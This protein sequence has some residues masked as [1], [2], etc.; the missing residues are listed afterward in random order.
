M[1]ESVPPAEEGAR[2]PDEGYARAA[3]ILLALAAVVG[4]TLGA[5]A[6]LL[7]S[8]ATDAWQSA[9]RQEIKRAAASVEDVRFVYSDEGPQVFSIDVARLRA[10]ELRKAAAAATGQ[11]RE[12]LTLEAETYSRYVAQVAK[13]PLPVGARYRTPEGGFDAPKRLADNRRRYP[14]LVAIDPQEPQRAGD[15][16]SRRAMFEIAATIPAALAFLLGALAEVFARPRRWLLL[17]GAA[18]VAAAAVAG[19]VL[20]VVT[21]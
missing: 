3:A 21:V 17:G 11:A 6:S 16:L 5:R 9:V 8:D 10:E 20:E 13:P 7:S 19:V 12:V 2:E 1:A 18:A 15:E 14:D 4:I